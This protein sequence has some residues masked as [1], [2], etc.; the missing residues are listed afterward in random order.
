MTK[1]PVIDMKRDSQDAERK[2]SPNVKAVNPE[3]ITLARVSRGLTQAELSRR[4]SVTQGWLSKVENGLLSVTEESLS[5]LAEELDY[6]VTFFVQTE[7]VYGMGTSEMFHRKRASVPDRVLDT[8]YARI[9][10]VRMHIA[11]MLRGVDIGEW[12]F[13]QMDVDEYGSPSAVAA[14]LRA[15]WLIPKGPI[16]NVVQ[17]IEEAGGIVIPFD[18]EGAKI[19]AIS[20]WVP[21]LPPLFFVNRNSPG[22]RLRFTLCH[23][24]GHI[25]M[26]TRAPHPDMEAQADEFAAEFLMPERDIRP[27]LHNLNLSK[28]AAL[29]LVWKVSMQALAVRADRLGLLTER[30]KRSLWKQLGP[31]RLR[32]PAELDI[33][34][35][36]PYLLDDICK[37]YLQDMGYTV[38]EFAQMLHLHEHEACQLYLPHKAPRLRLVKKPSRHG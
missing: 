29:K 36:T 4:L 34:I 5:R 37:A 24:I 38:E 7:R 15:H 8:V 17:V 23:E 30:Q 12:N 14:A 32:E 27:Y 25:V 19:D 31:Y 33:P 22:D 6:P 16:A 20:H 35:E 26:H 13:P 11:R 28:L 1:V 9:N 2:L 18:F 10:I 3:M 21:G